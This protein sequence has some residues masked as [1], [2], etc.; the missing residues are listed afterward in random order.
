MRKIT[1]LAAFGAAA[2]VAPTVA[3]SADTLTGNLSLSASIVAGCTAITQSTPFTFTGTLVENQQPIVQGAITTTCAATV[4]AEILF[5][6]GLNAGT[7]TGNTQQETVG[8]RLSSNTASASYIRYDLYSAVPTVSSQTLS[9][10]TAIVYGT[11]SAVGTGILTTGATGGA[12]VVTKVWAAL[13]APVPADQ[14]A[15]TYT[16]TIAVTLSF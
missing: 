9:G 15:G 1:A 8:P 3:T 2:V 12:P 11:T 13:D 7:L 4:P 14:A 6:T 5:N 10:G 16:D